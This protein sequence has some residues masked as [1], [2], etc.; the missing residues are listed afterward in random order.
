MEVQELSIGEAA[1]ATGLSVKTI[2]YYEEIGL[3]P[4]AQRRNTGA[5]TGGNLAQRRRLSEVERSARPRK[6][7]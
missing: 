2:R 1:N 6:R 7:T 3:I 5:H 4:E